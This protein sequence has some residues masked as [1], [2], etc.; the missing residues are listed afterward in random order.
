MAS[1]ISQDLKTV[2]M[3]MLNKKIAPE[4]ILQVVEAFPTCES[5]GVGS[6]AAKEAVAES[7]RHMAQRWPAAIYVDK[8]GKTTE[9]S[10]ASALYEELTGKKPSGSICDE[11]G[12]KC[13]AATLIDSFRFHGYIVQ[14]NGEDAPATD[15]D[16]P[17]LN[18]RLHSEWKEHLNATGKKIVIIHPKS[19]TIKQIQQEK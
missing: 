14:G 4:T 13:T 15:P 1:C 10:S 11:E 16:K 5:V 19:P 7:K 18:L 3:A 8:K 2:F 12:N 6:P 9:H 17:A